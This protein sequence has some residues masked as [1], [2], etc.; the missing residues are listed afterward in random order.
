MHNHGKL[1]W[2]LKGVLVLGFLF[3]YIPIF[4]LIIYSFNESKLVTV[5]GGFSTKWYGQLMRDVQILSAAWLSIKIATIS[6]LAASILGTIAGLVLARYKRFRGRT[7]FAGMVTAPMVMPEVITGLSM[8]LL[9]IQVQYLLR[10]TALYFERGIFTIWMGHTTLCMAYVAVL[11]RSRIIEMDKSLEE[12]ALDLGARPLKVFFVITLPLIMP[13]VASGFLLS[14]TLSLDDLVIASFLSGPGA[15]TL[16]IVVFSKIRLG[17]NPTINALATIFVVV[18]GV[19]VIGANY[20]MMR[21]QRQ[22]EK[23]IAA[24]MR[25]S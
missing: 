12:A 25:Q 13:A 3:L 10:G 7:L 4:S 9:V 16:P 2:Y 11:V 21:A 24:A 14:M 6:A 20:I 23:E 17:L 18:V 5:W 8:L 1:P 19:L 15:T 22:R